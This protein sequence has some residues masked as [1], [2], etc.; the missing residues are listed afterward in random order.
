[1]ASTSFVATPSVAD[2]AATQS[3]FPDWLL[4]P[5]GSEY[6]AQYNRDTTLH[7]QRA[8]FENI[9]DDIPAQFGM[10]KILFQK[11]PEYVA[12]D[13]FTWTE[14][15]WPRPTLRATAGVAGGAT[16]VITLATNNVAVVNDTIVYPD[17]THGIITAVN[18]AL[19]TITVATYNGAANL[20]AVV[21]NDVFI[22]ES[23]SIAD[24][25]DSFVHFD[26][27]TTINYT[28]YI[29]RGQRNKRWTTMTAQ[30]YKNNGTTNYFEKDAREMMELAMQDMFA[31][32]INGQ[33][34]EKNITVPAGTGLTAGTFVAKSSWGIFP[35]MQQNGAMHATSS[36]ATLE[37]DFKQLAFNSNYKN[38]NA[39][40]FILGTDRA[41]HA[42]STFM[43]DPIRYTPSDKAY[44][45]DLDVYKIGTMRFIPMVIP[46]F[47]ARSFMFPAAFE[48][49]LL[50][51][52]LDSIM[53]ICMQGFEPMMV[54][55][56]GNLHKSKGGYNDYIDY[57]I[58]Y[59]VSM[60]MENVDGNFWID[61]INI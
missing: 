20:P 51:L 37:A 31:T 4:N 9:V 24:G 29:G 13:V 1:M 43:K 30:K 27:M 55:N 33:K 53:P 41:L 18:N 28:N 34:G 14:R 5:I 38:V 25:M 35:F 61:L 48:N 58:E 47:E 44:D 21:A 60:K 22:I 54:R 46:L 49:R 16:Q 40:R 12:D 50:V 8:I 6:A 36:P 42:M 32:F 59:M 26:R 39:P 10:F 17:N 45:M 3:L 57:F 56:T 11:Q 15:L 2:P 19:N 7:L 23:A 52:D